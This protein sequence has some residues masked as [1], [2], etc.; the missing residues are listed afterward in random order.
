MEMKLLP[1][2]QCY[3]SF[4]A[5]LKRLPPREAREV[6]RWMGRN[7]LFF[8]LRFLLHRPDVDGTRLRGDWVFN[9]CREVQANPDGRLDLWAREHYKS[10]IIT[11]ALTVQSL[12]NDPELT[13]AI[14]SHTRD[15]AKKFLGQIK[16]ELETNDELKSLYP[17]ILWEQPDR[18]APTWS[19]DGGIKVK[20]K[21]NPK[22][23]SVEAWGVVDSQPTS[24]H[25]D[26]LV[27]DDLVTIDSVNTDDS[28]KKVTD[29]WSLS[30]N[31]GKEGGVKRYAG[32][33]YHYNDTYREMKQ[34]KAAI[35]RQ[36]PATIDGTVE[37]EPVM[38]TR[39]ELKL[40]RRDQGPYVFSS[41]MLMDPKAEETQGFVREWLRHYHK[42]TDG[43]GMN[44]YIVVDPA[45]EKKKENDYTAMWVVGLAADRNYYVLDMVRDRLNL[46]ERWDALLSLHQRY[47]PLGVGYERYGKDA[48][49]S[50]YQAEMERIKYRFEITA[51][52]GVKNKKDRIRR[53]IPLFD[54][55]RIW[56]PLTLWKT[57]YTK[58]RE[59]LV[60]VFVEDE[61]LP[62][63]VSYHDDML[64]ALARMVDPDF[65]TRWPKA[66]ARDG[67]KARER[68][69]KKT[70]AR[71][72]G[73]GWAA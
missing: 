9:R 33:I 6:S 69:T 58:E 61:F 37:G 3:P 29:R 56:L 54:D 67:K 36:Y 11:F 20:R 4:F 41:Q 63:P 35:P 64:D 47:K 31:L 68:Y 34:R 17:E 65:S 22:E 26:V 38:M 12:L 57:N 72:A 71:G 60:Q 23:S 30:L 39:D 52:G 19:L 32:T 8:L 49:I 5:S 42:P 55:G 15:I 18:E 1:N 53:L 24:K 62:F 51:L 59:D 48:D 66:S 7:D 28:I 40:R 27:F 45:N 21:G 73:S 13:V 44:K 43:S 16:D 25:F 46:V 14:F 70:A 2:R 50:H 10:S